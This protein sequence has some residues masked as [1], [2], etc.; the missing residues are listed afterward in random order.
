MI[1]GLIPIGGQGTRLGLP[2][3]KEMLPQKNY[4]FYNP[5]SNHLVQKMLFAGAEKIVFIHGKSFKQDVASFYSDE[6]KYLH[7]EQKELGFAQIL[8]DFY[9]SANPADNDQCLFGLPDSVFDGNPFMEML[10]Y[11]GICAGLFTTTDSTK[12]DRLT[13]C[14]TRFEVKSPKTSSNSDRFWGIIKFNGKNLRQFYEDDIFSKTK[15][16]GD[17]LNIYGFNRVNGN[18]YID[19]GTWEN[20]NKYLSTKS[21]SADSEIE[22]KYLANDVN[23]DAFIGIFSNNPDFTYEQVNSADY[24]FSPTNEKIEFIRYREQPPGATFPSDIT[25]KDSNPNSLNRFELVM[26]LAQ[27]TQTQTA[28]TFLNLIASKFEFK[29]RKNCHIFTSTEAVLVLYSFSVGDKTIKLIEIELLQ[30]DFNILA[31][32][33][34]LL[35]QLEGFSVSNHVNISK[36]KMIKEMIYD[37]AH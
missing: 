36:Y 2:Y 4:G 8:R 22:K 1:Y 21:I 28:L 7:V 9:L 16:I 14:S 5:V 15:E 35:T 26:Q 20:Y 34:N 19:I 30:A 37:A 17:I 12:V 27:E 25:I 13:S 29:I 23:E 6:K 24:Y 11:P 3:S 32:F 31:K 10:G 18:N 33:E